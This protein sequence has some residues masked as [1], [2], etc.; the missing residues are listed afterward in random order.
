MSTLR[1][2]GLQ[3]P[4]SL[5]VNGTLNSDGSTTFGGPLNFATGST[6]TPAAGGTAPTSPSIGALWYDTGATPDTLKVWDGFSWVPAGSGGGGGV[7]SITAGTGLTGGTITGSGTIALDSTAVIAPSILTVKGSLISASAANTPVALA[8]GSNGQYLTANSACTSGL[9]WVTAGAGGV[10]N[11][12]ATAPIASTG[13]ATPVI[14]ITP[15]TARQLLQTNT[16]GTAAE[17]ASNID[18]PGTLDVTGA[19]T[20]DSNVTVTGSYAQLNAQGNLRFADSDSSNYVAFQAA[21]TVPSNI[22]WTLPAADGTTGQVLST[23]GSGTLSWAT[24]SASA[25]TPIVAGTVLGCTNATTTAIGCNAL[26]VSSGVCN[27][28][29]GYRALVANTSGVNNSAF[30]YDALCANDIGGFNT[31]IGISA[32]CSNTSGAGNTAVGNRSLRSNSTACN[33]SAFGS[34]ALCGNTLGTQNT[35]LG[36]SALDSNGAGSFNTAAGFQALC[37]N[38]SGNCNAALGVNALISNTTGCNNV[39]LGYFSGGD[40]LCSLTTQSNHVILGND[41]TSVIYGKVAY[42]N[43]S[44]VRWK[45]VE[46]EV[47]LALDFVKSLTP[48]KYQFCNRNTGEVT[49]ERYRYGFSA[50]EVIANEEISDHPIIARIDNPEMYSLNETMFIPVLVNAIKELAADNADLRSRLEALES[51]S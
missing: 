18:I 45:K 50:Q 14:S 25:A 26:A 3:N 44:D 42:T 38:S 46:S 33:N 17:F 15:G 36:Q 41:S 21:A 28:A 6:V 51:A 40:T 32:L 43:A 30:G 39:A 13:G 8:P 29:V 7:T 1:V 24:S 20:F 47:P 16:G 48:I 49:D 12:T 4:T 27:T 31:A 22:V 37:V 19:A 35:G 23:N 10:T 2:I 34:R 5:V 11:V 9:E